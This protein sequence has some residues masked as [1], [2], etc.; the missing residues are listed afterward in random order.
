MNKALREST[1]PCVVLKERRVCCCGLSLNYRLWAVGEGVGTR[2]D[3]E[4]TLGN[5]GQRAT[6]GASVE[7]ALELFERI[8]G[9]AVTPCT[10]EEV[11]FDLQTVTPN[12]EKCN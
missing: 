1:D 2:Y 7:S 9:G 8:C 10:L 4:A 5:E 6:L 11:V 3:V 12:L